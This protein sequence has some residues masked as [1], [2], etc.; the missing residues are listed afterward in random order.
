MIEVVGN[1]VIERRES[2][3]EWRRKVTLPKNKTLAEFD[4]GIIDCD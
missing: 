2:V 3:Q 1:G 4:D